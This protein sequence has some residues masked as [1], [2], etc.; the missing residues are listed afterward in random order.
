MSGGDGVRVVVERADSDVSVALQEAFFADIA[1]RY[2]GWT[3]GSSQKVEP[4]ELAPPSGIWLVAY[5]DGRA[6]GC[7][8]LQR[9]D[10]LTAEVRRIYL[11]ASARGRGIGRTLLRELELNALGFGYGRVRLT[12]GDGQPEAL[13]LFQSVGYQEI[14]PFT[15]GTFTT[16]WMEKTL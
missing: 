5:L 12:T 2:P 16:H 9:L 7:G 3:P 6:V 14:E 15:D 8:G 4:A 10:E 11:D 1:T 13:G